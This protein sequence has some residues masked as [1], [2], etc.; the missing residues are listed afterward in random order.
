M[1]KPKLG[2]FCSREQIAI[3]EGIQSNLYRE[4]EITPWSQGFFRSNEVAL[5]TFL[6]RIMLLDAAVVILGDDD[7][8]VSQSDRNETVYVPRDNVIF[9][10]GALMERLGPKKT[11]VVVPEIPTVQLPSYLL[12]YWPLTYENRQ[13]KNYVAGT[14]VAAAQIKKMFSELG[15]VA[16]YSDLPA[17]GLALGFF[18]NF[19]QP[20]YNRLT[21]GADLSGA[22]GSPWRPADGFRLNIVVPEGFVGR[23]QAEHFYQKAGLSKVDLDLGRGRNISLHA[24][25]GKSGE[26]SLDIYDIPTTLLTSNKAIS[27]VDDFWGKGDRA[28]K[29]DLQKQEI[30]NFERSLLDVKTESDIGAE[31]KVVSY[32]QF[33]SE[34]NLPAWEDILD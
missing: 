32:K 17:V 8:R 1:A 5:T 9:E 33:Q 20:V 18:S 16:F 19:V 23:D 31:V 11:F 14:G 13:D 22:P 29:E 25:R 28:F 6:K 34:F 27:L 4:F 24:C 15:R 10:M 2:I 7:L 12:G 26:K 3:A 30:K 21:Q